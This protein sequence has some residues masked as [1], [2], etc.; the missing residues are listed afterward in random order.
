MILP[1]LVLTGLCQA[2]LAQS[3]ICRQEQE[4]GIAVRC[5]T[6]IWLCVVS[7]TFGPNRIFVGKV[8][9]VLLDYERYD[10]PIGEGSWSYVQNVRLD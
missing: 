5:S 2:F 9:N 10:T 6:R 1:P 7:V 8:G 4:W 3:N